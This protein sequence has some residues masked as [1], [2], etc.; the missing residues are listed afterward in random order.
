MILDQWNT[1]SNIYIYGAGIYGQWVRHYLLVNGLG[2]KIEGYL[3][4]KKEKDGE[5]ERSVPIYEF[6]DKMEDIEKYFIVIAMNHKHVNEVTQVL[7][8]NSIVNYHIITDEEIC[9]I[10]NYVKEAY[11][12]CSLVWN[13]IFIK[14]YSGS[15]YMC[16]CKYVAEELRKKKNLELIWCVENEDKNDIPDDIITVKTGT[17][18]FYYYWFTSRVII[19]NDGLPTELNKRKDQYLINTWHGIGPFKKTCLD[20]ERYKNDPVLFEAGKHGHSMT[21][22]MTAASNH[23]HKVYRQAFLFKGEIIDSGYPRN[24]IFFKGKDYKMKIKKKVEE[25]LGIKDNQ[26]IVMYAPTYRYNQMEENGRDIALSTYALDFNRVIDAIN[27]RFKGVHK[28]IYRLHLAT[29]HWIQRGIMFE[30]GIDATDY[31]DMQELL[32]AADILI[33]DFSSSIWDFSLSRKP[34]F[35][36]YNDL[37]VA[38]KMSGFYLSPEEYPYPKGHST[39]ELVSAINDFDDAMYQKGLDEWF[40]TYGTFDDGHASERVGE[41]VMEVVYNQ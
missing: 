9:Y 25:A 33:T 21:D 39:D 15:N 10:K 18:D 41:R 17:A 22:L 40:N 28:F 13:R 8:N 19:T 4:T 24:D 32:L 38:E 37:S 14:S 16:N 23:C 2:N 20:S 26:K 5:K 3:V 6:E 29:D 34:I 27:T 35:L 1:G 31:P 30:D 36:F 7:R 12:K 11:G